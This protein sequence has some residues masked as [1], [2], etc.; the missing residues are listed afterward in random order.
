MTQAHEGSLFART[1]CYP[2][3]VRSPRF[4]ALCAPLNAPLLGIGLWG[5]SISLVAC[6]DGAP[7]AV[8]IVEPVYFAQAHQSD[9]TVEPGDKF[10]LALSND[11]KVAKFVRRDP[12][13]PRVDGK[14]LTVL[15]VGSIPDVWQEQ[16]GGP[17][18]AYVFEVL[19]TGRSKVVVFDAAHREL[20][21]MNV[22][23]GDPGEEPTKGRVREEP[24]PRVINAKEA[25]RGKPNSDLK[26]A[27]PQA[28][29]DPKGSKKAQT[30]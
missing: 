27:K 13:R 30:P 8:S 28:K 15:E 14:I 26:G 21:R 12:R 19:E 7:A 29:N 4:A 25:P 9:I 3:R 2:S 16:A 17:G 24:L 11:P 5:A 18:N 6:G 20:F 1:S 22:T 10:A 23:S